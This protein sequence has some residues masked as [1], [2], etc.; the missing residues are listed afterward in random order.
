MFHMELLHP[1]D[2][3]LLHDGI[4]RMDVEHHRIRHL[5]HQVEDSLDHLSCQP[6][7]MNS[8]LLPAVVHQRTTDTINVTHLRKQIQI[9]LQLSH[10]APT[11]NDNTDTLIQCPVHRGTRTGRDLL[12]AVEQCS[13][14]IQCC[15]LIFSHGSPSG[16]STNVK[17][18][19]KN[20][21]RF[22]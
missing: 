8:H 4:H 17:E 14:H 18:A 20:S 2:I 6:C 15:D 11:V 9:L 16:I 12:F 3:A 21:C 22:P 7:L 13:I 5:F 1:L 10:I 19:T